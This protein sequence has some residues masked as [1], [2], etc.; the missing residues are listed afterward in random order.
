MGLPPMVD[1]QH[2][3]VFLRICELKSFTKAAVSLGV[4]QPSVSYTVKELER[5]WGAELF[6]RTGRGVVLSEFGE[7]A[8]LRARSLMDAADEVFEELRSHNGLPSGV[9]KQQLPRS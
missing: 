2:L 1:L 6:Y 3:R 8:A 7:H 4:T 9:V 5:A